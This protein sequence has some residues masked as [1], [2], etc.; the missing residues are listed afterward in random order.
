[1]LLKLLKVN[2]TF[3]ALVCTEST[4]DCIGSGRVHWSTLIQKMVNLVIMRFVEVLNCDTT[5]IF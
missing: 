1:M 4:S 2:T 3:V 5:A